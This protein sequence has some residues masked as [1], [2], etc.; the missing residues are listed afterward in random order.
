MVVSQR[1][2]ALGRRSAAEAKLLQT[3]E[4]LTS[5]DYR[6]EVRT[7][8]E[9]RRRLE[10]VLTVPGEVPVVFYPDEAWVHGRH[11]VGRLVGR[12][13]EWRQ[14]RPDSGSI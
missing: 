8:A 11:L 6:V 5:R 12:A 4:L 10:P 13:V 1:P 9:V 7:G 2:A 14:E 3:A